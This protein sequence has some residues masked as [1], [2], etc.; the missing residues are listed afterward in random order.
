[1]TIPIQKYLY[2]LEKQWINHEH[3]GERDPEDLKIIAMLREAVNGLSALA[4]MGSGLSE[5]KKDD[6]LMNACSY[7]AY[8]L[9]NMDAIM[10]EE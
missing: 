3:Y 1:M 4:E 2:E 8:I 5:I 9:R 10:G 7:S 6:I